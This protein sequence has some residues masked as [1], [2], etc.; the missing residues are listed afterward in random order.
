MTRKQLIEK[1]KLEGRFCGSRVREYS[2]IETPELVA[3][4]RANN[5]DFSRSTAD[6]RNHPDFG[7]PIVI[8]TLFFDRGELPILAPADDHSF[9][10]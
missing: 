2:P 5:I 10:G 7:K 3:D 6:N 1:Y 4:L 8:F 9:F